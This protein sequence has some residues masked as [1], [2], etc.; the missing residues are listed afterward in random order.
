M[1]NVPGYRLGEIIGSG[2]GGTV[3]RGVSDNGRHVAVKIMHVGLVGDPGQVR[4]WLREA[5]LAATVDH[6]GVVK[7][8]DV[9]V[10]DDVAWLVM[11]ELSGPDLKHELSNCGPLP[12]DKATRFMTQIADAM[13]AVHAAG[14][15]HRDLKP[16][17]I[18]L[19]NGMPTLVDFGLPGRSPTS[20][21]PLASL[22]PNRRVGPAPPTLREVL[23]RSALPAHTPGWRQSNGEAN[24]RRQQ[25]TSMPSGVCCSRF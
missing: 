23:M 18:V 1:T 24:K 11:D 13:A 12:V 8:H 22:H 20:T 17:N 10:S 19:N 7:V 6:P 21:R 5:R 14:L 2:S 4:R 15:V 25:P 3:Y 16:G 9:G